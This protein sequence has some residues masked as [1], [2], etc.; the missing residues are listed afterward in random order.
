MEKINQSSRLGKQEILYG[1]FP[2]PVIKQPLLPVLD[3]TIPPVN[4]PLLFEVHIL[5][6]Y[7][8]CH[9]LARRL[10][11][12]AQLDSEVL[13]G[14]QLPEVYL[15]LAFWDGVLRLLEMLGLAEAQGLVVAR[16]LLLE[17]VY[18]IYCDAVR[19]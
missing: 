11:Y 14:F 10:F 4:H 2:N 18:S 6:A 9:Y 17:Y 7:Q 15:D 19:I 12:F 8:V 5:P 3:L 16:V 13:S 1:H